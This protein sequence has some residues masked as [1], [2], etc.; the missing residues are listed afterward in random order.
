MQSALGIQSK[1]RRTTRAAALIAVQLN[2]LY[3]GCIVVIVM[4]ILSSLSIAALV[5]GLIKH[6]E[7]PIQAWIPQWL[8][9]F[10]SV[11]LGGRILFITMFSLY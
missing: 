2:V 9:I 6:S 5:I 1:Q 8:I 3:C 4:T 7:C 10:G 11:G